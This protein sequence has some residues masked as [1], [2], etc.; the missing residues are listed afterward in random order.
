MEPITQTEG[1]PQEQVTVESDILS[2]AQLEAT[3]ND[4][5]VQEPEPVLPSEEQTEELIGGKFKS[6]EDLLQAYKE[7]EK[8]LGTPTTDEEEAPTEEPTDDKEYLQWKQEKEQKE[9]LQDVG[10][11]DT[12]KAAVKWA[13]ENLS[14]AEIKIYNEALAE[15]GTSKAAVKLL[16]KGLIDKYSSS[17]VPTPDDSPIHSNTPIKPQNTKGY[18][19]KSD[20]LKDIG[21]PRYAKDPTFRA[22]VEAKVAVTNF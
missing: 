7:L 18:E 21:D 20:M 13:G 4:T 17:N 3:V 19:T 8:K 10:G 15:A 2:E 12:Y 11:L 16:A 22:K 14:E 5:P 9:L 1:Q 6:Q